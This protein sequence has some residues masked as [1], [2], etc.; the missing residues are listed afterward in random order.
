[1][2]FLNRTW[3]QVFTWENQEFFPAQFFPISMLAKQATLLVL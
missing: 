2:W 3:I 1:M